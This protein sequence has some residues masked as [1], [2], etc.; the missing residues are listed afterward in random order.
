MYLTTRSGVRLRYTDRGAGAPLLLVHGWKSSHRVW[1][2]LLQAMSSRFRVIAFDLRGMGESDKPADGYAFAQLADDLEDVLRE[3]DLDDVTL[4]AWSMGCTVTLEWLRRGGGDRIG[5]LVLMSG[6]IKLTRTP[7]FPWSLPAER[8][9]LLIEQM[10]RRWPAHEREFAEGYFLDPHPEVVDWVVQTA[11]QTP[12]HV[13]VETLREQAT[14]D[15][16]AM[17]PTIAVP[18]LAI[19]GAHDRAYPRDLPEYIAERVPRCEGLVFESSAHFPFLEEQERFER[20]LTE[21][22]TRPS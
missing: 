11:L 6:P 18:T 15:F 9:E 22:A 2:R 16:R 1:D 21:F 13:A 20:V 14:H 7:D 5:R 12:V 19:Y 10:E 17:L 8:I 4:V 3:L